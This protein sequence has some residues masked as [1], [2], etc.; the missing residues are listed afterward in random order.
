MKR[1][2]LQPGDKVVAV[3]PEVCSGAGWSNSVAWLII[4]SR[5]GTLREE[6]LQRDEQPDDLRRLF[7]IGAAVCEELRAT[8]QVQQ[9][10]Q[11]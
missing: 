5:D 9:Q 7:R 6:C 1:T 10:A 8:V 2:V 11:Q 4:R 3:V